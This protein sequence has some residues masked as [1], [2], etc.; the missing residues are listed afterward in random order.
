MPEWIKIDPISGQ[1][2]AEPPNDIENIKLKIISES[3]EGEISVKEIE[4]NFKK[5]S[6]NSG[7][8]IDPETTF[9]PL[10]AQL[11]KEKFNFDDYGD[12][13]IRSL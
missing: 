2:I 7:K 1:I 13:L 6:E 5:E 8:L 10:N 3:E 4:L 12:K 9:E 11:A